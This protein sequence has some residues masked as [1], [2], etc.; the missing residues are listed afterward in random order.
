MGSPHSQPATTP[1]PTQPAGK[2]QPQQPR[3][4]RPILA[5]LES[6]NCCNR[7]QLQRNITMNPTH[8]DRLSYIADLLELP[9]P[10]PAT[11]RLW[12]RDALQA[13]LAGA[14]P[15]AALGIEGK[16][17][18]QARNTIIRENAA[19]LAWSNSGRARILA[20]Q[21]RRLHRGRRSD[22]SWLARADRLH[23]LPETE[24]QFHNI[25]K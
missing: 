23:R 1:T 13:I 6:C 17:A 22:L 16:A 24:R 3:G 12:L 25:L 5:S 14:D 2:P 8:S 18:R 9:D 15:A 21:A 10:L 11:T 20:E 4:L 7:L 19:S